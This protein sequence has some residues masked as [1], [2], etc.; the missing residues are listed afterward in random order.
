[1]KPLYLFI[2]LILITHLNHSFSNSPA[3]NPIREKVLKYD[4]QLEQTIQLK[5][6]LGQS[7]FVNAADLEKLKGVKIHHIDLV[8]SAYTGSNTVS[9]DQ[10]H[11]Q[12]IQNLKMALPQVEKDK[13]TWK[14]IEQTGAKS[15][16][17]AKTYFHGFV[18]HYGPDLSYQHLKEF[19]KPFQTA[20]KTFTVSAKEGGV[21]DCGGGT[22]VNIAGNSVTYLDGTPVNG[23]FTFAY[24]EFKDPTDFAFSGIPMTYNDGREDL[25]F[26]S[27]G[28]YNL[29]GEQNGKEL[30]L[31]APVKVDFN[32]TKP[33]PGVAFY[34]MDD[35][36]GEWTKKKEVNYGGSKE[37]LKYTRKSELEFD[38]H[39]FELN[40]K[41]YE[42]YADIQFDEASWDW[43]F[44][45]LAS[46]PKLNA[47]VKQ[48]DESEKT[49]QTTVE[50]KELMDVVTAIMIEEKKTEM[51]L[52]RAERA[53]QE[54]QRQKAEAEKMAKLRAENQKYLDA[55]AANGISSPS[56]VNGLNSPD[57][58]V[59]NC[60]QLYKLEEPLALSP[61]YV[62][63]NGVEITSKHV[64]CVMDL[65]FNGSFSF[66]PNNI[67]CSGV[68]KNVIL[69]FTDD[70]SVFMLS[71]QQFNRLDLKENLRPVFAMKNMTSIIKKSDDLKSYLN[72]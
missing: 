10:L 42:N 16:K 18:V 51:K 44:K 2:S 71:E 53:A 26:S 30:D 11:V 49:A 52:E 12:R 58:G 4:F 27:V 41:I 17:E 34:Q 64:V 14:F 60:D 40:S 59:Y 55:V 63:E 19:F 70:K 32:C 25:N 23:D 5:A 72:I 61:T 24:N 46:Y 50:P 68:G 37:T 29:R 54:A 39:Y 57:F 28:M 20:T 47:L 7:V 31:K 45:H 38:G 67:K 21:F 36:T 15:L 6:K 35:V 66:H 48:F 1:M 43:F 9:Q 13:P 56:L 69:L 62:D 65:N 8:Y 33:A 22:T 3:D